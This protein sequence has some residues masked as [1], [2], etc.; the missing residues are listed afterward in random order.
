MSF[1]QAT[2]PYDEK[3]VNGDSTNGFGKLNFFS[4][5]IDWTGLER[6]LRDH[7]WNLEFRACNPEEMFKKFVEICIE[8]ST[9]YVPFRKTRVTSQTKSFIPRDRKNLMRRKR[10]I[11][12]QLKKTTSEAKRKKL[13]GES[14]QVER[15]LIK[16]YQQSQKDRETKA[17]NAIKIN[18]KYFFSYAKKFSTTKIGIG[19]FFD[20]AKKLVT[21]PIKMA[22]MLSE[23]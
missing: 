9:K 12:A 19:P 21:S 5:D 6:E 3:P 8:I 4:E 22:E 2:L 7:N 10:R 18:S 13:K 14:V 20:Y 1:Y 23:Q 15:A 16:S 17:V 11:T